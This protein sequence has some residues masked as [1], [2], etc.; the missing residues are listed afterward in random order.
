MLSSVGRCAAAPK[1][2]N[3]CSPPSPPPGTDKVP[4]TSQGGNVR[5]ERRVGR[6][7]TG[8]VEI[9]LIIAGLRRMEIVLHEVRMYGLKS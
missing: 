2:V 1:R 9:D 3:R 6:G 8:S 5:E 4:A 7:G